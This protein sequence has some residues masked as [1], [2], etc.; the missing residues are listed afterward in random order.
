MP[1]VRRRERDRTSSAI[2]SAS[3]AERGERAA[4]DRAGERSGRRTRP[5]PGS[6][7]AELVRDLDPRA[8]RR[9]R[10]GRLDRPGHVHAL[11]RAGDV[12]E[13]EPAG[14][15][16][17][18]GP[19]APGHRA[20]RARARARTAAARR[21]RTRASRRPRGG[22]RARAAVVGEQPLPARRRRGRAGRRARGGAAMSI[23]IV[24]CISDAPARAPRRS[25]GTAGSAAE[26]RE[27]DPGREVGRAV[28]LVTELA[29]RR[30]SRGTGCPIEW[31]PVAARRRR[32]LEDRRADTEQ[33]VHGSPSSPVSSRSSRR[34]PVGRVLAE[35]E[36]AAGQ[37]PQ[38]RRR[39]P[40]ADPVS[41]TASPPLDPRVGGDP[42]PA[43][44]TP[45]PARVLA[46]GRRSAARNRGSRARDAGTRSPITRPIVART[47]SR[48][49][50]R[51]PA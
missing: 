29:V 13:P 21:S 20:A 17:V 44:T 37:R 12:D 33:R 49:A 27:R 26:L 48:R 19:A 42:R 38:R 22:R 35:V 8:A 7:G 2:A 24:E 40:A 15:G 47:S 14:R 16:L 46:H 10:A 1:S 45:R 36:A 18:P 9:R 28:D 32:R 39:R 11:R 4:R 34:T 41:R 31:M 23:P 25:S 6:R 30:P 50:S 5:C 43:R 51:R 3:A